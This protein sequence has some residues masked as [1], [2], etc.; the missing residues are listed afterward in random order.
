MATRG[1][2]ASPVVAGGMVSAA[3]GA[4]EHSD[5]QPFKL[6]QA[7]DPTTGRVLW[8]AP[9]ILHHWSSPIVV[10]RIVYLAQGGAGD[11]QA[12]T[13]GEFTP[14]ALPGRT[15]NC[16]NDFSLAVHPASRSAAPRTSA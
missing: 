13:S 2:T 12:G 11:R 4:G 10:N 15:G 14:G 9:T 8:D 7:L 3:F 16:G 6:I 5:T 1:F